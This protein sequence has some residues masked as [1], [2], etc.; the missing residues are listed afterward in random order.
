M[1]EEDGKNGSLHR[2]YLNDPQPEKENFCLKAR[3]DLNKM[4]IQF[5]QKKWFSVLRLNDPQPEREKFC[6]KPRVDLHKITIHSFDLLQTCSR[7]RQY[8]NADL[9]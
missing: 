7:S 8:K 3:V 6:L 5:I 1:R 4:S 2:D 9:I